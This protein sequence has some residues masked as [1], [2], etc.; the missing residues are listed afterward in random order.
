MDI[1]AGAIAVVTGGG[2]GIGRALCRQ[3]AAA[4]VHVAACDLDDDGMAGTRALALEGAPPGTRFTTFHAD[5][6]RE[7][8]VLAFRDATLAA[9][10]TDH[11]D[12][13]LNNAGIGG[14]G[15]FVAGDRAEWERTFGVCWGGVYNVARAFLPLLVASR[16]AMLVNVSSVN[17]FW[18]ALRAGIPHTAYSAAKFAV[19]GFTEALITDLRTN[20]PHVKCAV[21]MP[22]HIGTSIMRNSG[23]VHGYG[24]A[25][26]MSAERVA[27]AREQIVKAGFPVAGLPDDTIRALLHQRAEEFRDKAPTTAEQA[28]TIIL[29]GVRAGR[30]RILVGED[31]HELD[32]R[33]RADPAHAYDGGL[34]EVFASMRD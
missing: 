12:L 6:S 14:G 26:Q 19:K 29:A 23:R 18:A 5:V 22:G 4:G 8:D 21:V 7:A 13:V 31:A 16:E 33:V 28:A 10:A 24:D 20:A 1:R 27:V 32:R 11:V 9:H 25:L 30:W 34:K 3:L 2:S 17:G 15:S